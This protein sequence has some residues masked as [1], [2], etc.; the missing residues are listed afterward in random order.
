[1]SIKIFQLNKLLL[2]ITSGSPAQR[3]VVLS[4]LALI[5]ICAVMLSMIASLYTSDSEAS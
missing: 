2:V 1:M 5:I 3:V 4:N